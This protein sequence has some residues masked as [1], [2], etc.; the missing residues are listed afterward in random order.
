MGRDLDARGLRTMCGSQAPPHTQN[1]PTV[2][3][4]LCPIEKNK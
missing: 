1:V 3:S 2:A 4:L